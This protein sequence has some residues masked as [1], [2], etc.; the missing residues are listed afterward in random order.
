MSHKPHKC[1]DCG[2]EIASGARCAECQAKKDA[3]K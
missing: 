3:Q 1:N 2:K